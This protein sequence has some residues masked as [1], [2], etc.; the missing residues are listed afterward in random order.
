[1]V[2]ILEE[3]GLVRWR[4]DGERL[5]TA[6]PTLLGGFGW[7]LLHTRI[8]GPSPEVLALLGEHGYLPAADGMVVHRDDIPAPICDS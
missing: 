3:L 7:M 4:P 2:G 1:M 6:Q 5:G 8:D